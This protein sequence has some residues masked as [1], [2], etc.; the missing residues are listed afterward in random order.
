MLRTRFDLLQ[1]VHGGGPTTAAQLLRMLLLMLLNVV[2]SQAQRE[3][4]NERSGEP[5]EIDEQRLVSLEALE[6]RFCQLQLEQIN[7][8]GGVVA[9]SSEIGTILI[10]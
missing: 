8:R 7:V 6:C 5:V 9:A 2:I 10:A 3:Q 4:R 1:I